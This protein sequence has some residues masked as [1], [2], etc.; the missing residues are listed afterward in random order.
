MTSNPTACSHGWTPQAITDC[1]YCKPRQ[2]DTSARD[3]EAQSYAFMGRFRENAQ[4]AY[5]HPWV[6]ARHGFECGHAQATAQIGDRLA[7]LHRRIDRY[8][9]E[10][11]ALYEQLA[12][13]EKRADAYEKCNGSKID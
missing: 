4:N 6:A 1:P 8:I 7:E 10:N 11:C 9:K 2:P 13:S 3:S 5:L 12:A